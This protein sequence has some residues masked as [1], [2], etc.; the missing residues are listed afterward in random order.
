MALKLTKS[1]ASRIVYYV[2]TFC[3]FLF[4]ISL[5]VFYFF[6]KKSIED[7]TYEN[8]LSLMQNTVYKTEQVLLTTE[9]ISN[10][11]KY[12]FESHQLNCDSIMFY[13]WLIVKN[14]PEIVGCAIAFAPEFFPEKGY[15]FSPYTYRENGELHST[16]LGSAE[17]D[18]FVMDWYLIPATI[19]KTYWC[20]P[21]YDTGGVD[22]LITTYSIPFY[23]YS[24]NERTLAGVI[25][26]DL[27]LEWL[28]DIV[29]SVHIFETGYAS[30]ISRNGTFVT[31]PNTDLIMNQTI[32]SWATELGSPHL[33]DIGRDMQ[34]GNTNFVSFKH[35][36]L[37]LII[38]Y[39]PL[40]SSGWS[41]AVVFPRSEMYAPLTRI[42][43]VLIVLIVVG[44]GLLTFIVAKIVTRQIAPLKYFAKS[45]R[46]VADGNFD[47]KLP[48]ITTEDEMKDLQNSF[49][50]MQKDLKTYIEHLK[51]TTSAKEKIESELRIAREIQMGMIPKIFPPF[52][53]IPEIDIYAMLEP[54]K[55][56]GGDLYDFFLIDEKHLC[57]AIGDVSGKGVPASLF[58]AVTRTLL[59]SAAPKQQSPKLIVEALNKS[60]SYNN[61]S[62]MFVTFFLGII[63]IETG[64]MQYT[65]AGHNPPVIIHEN[66]DVKMFDVTKDIPIGLFAEHEYEEKEMTFSPSDRIFLYTDGVTE[67]ENWD[68]QLYSEEKLLKCLS[69]AN[70]SEPIEIVMSVARDVVIH[71][72]DY[73]QSDD[74]TMMCI[75]YYGK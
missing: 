28:T 23:R 26:I 48:E 8:A 53:D 2:L 67:A 5:S 32:F 22:A 4:L 71:V 70:K 34:A 74:L 31:H 63:N 14:N 52:P 19:E 12:L 17:Y 27:S 45:A 30:V 21:Y 59:R 18:Y 9:K 58:M 20:E 66:G 75:I 13:T 56:V 37:N 11:Y 7:T 41:L 6:S 25:A 44:L 1:L 10:N 54:A 69:L 35:E 57:F 38:S 60:L 43:I 65:N 50:H 49:E 73:L 68:A 24:G 40:V 36:K 39:T 46:E 3:I 64:Y 33:R 47:N 29:S 51:E 55:E 62:S 72:N 15:Y 61:E 16:I 42:S